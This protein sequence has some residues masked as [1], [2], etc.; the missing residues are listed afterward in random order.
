MVLIVTATPSVQIILSQYRY[1]SLNFRVNDTPPQTA[2]QSRERGGPSLCGV[3]E[4]SVHF[5][6][7]VRMHHRLHGT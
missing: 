6:V 7:C 5:D 4:V 2:A 3:S 1:C